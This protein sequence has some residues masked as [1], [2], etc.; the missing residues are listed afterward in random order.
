MLLEVFGN[1]DVP[2][3][4]IFHARLQRSLARFFTVNEKGCLGW[5]SK[6]LEPTHDVAGIRMS[7][8]RIDEFDVCRNT[9]RKTV[10]LDRLGAV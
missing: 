3:Q 4:L 9:H 5:L 1:L 7:G 2:A 6:T 10:D 8:K